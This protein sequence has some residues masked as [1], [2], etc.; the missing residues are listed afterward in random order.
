[1]VRIQRSRPGDGAVPGLVGVPTDHKGLNRLLP[2]RQSGRQNLLRRDRPGRTPCLQ[3][4]WPR[5]GDL[6][7]ENE[8]ALD[9]PQ[10]AAS[11]AILAEW[12]DPAAACQT[13]KPPPSTVKNSATAAEGS[14]VRRDRRHRCAVHYGG[15]HGRVQRDD[16]NRP[17]RHGRRSPQ[18]RGRAQDDRRRQ[19]VTPSVKAP[20][21]NLV[22]PGKRRGG[23]PDIPAA[24]EDS[25]H[26][27]VGS[28]TAGGAFSQRRLSSSIGS[29]TRV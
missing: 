2:R 25:A 24:V 11:A 7:G 1:M 22:A 15:H 5:R 28:R 29:G 19:Q 10:A 3:P 12:C 6:G 20:P 16:P 26:R 14:L 21:P 27:T 23:A 17:S 4:R 9:R 13:V 8:C 18:R